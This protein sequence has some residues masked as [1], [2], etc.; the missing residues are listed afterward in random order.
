MTPLERC[1]YA[2]KGFFFWSDSVVRVIKKLNN[3]FA[4]CVD[5]EGKEC[6]AYGKGIGFPKT[7]YDITDSTVIDR[8]FY[9]VDQKYLALFNELPEKVLHFTVKLVDIARN[10][11]D[12][13]LNPNVVLTLAD[14]INFCIQRAKQHIYVQMPLIYEVEQQYPQE[15]RLGR[16]ALK[17]IERRFA[18]QLNQNEASGIALHF[19]NARYNA[20]TKCDVTMQW[21]QRYDDV[22]EDTVSIVEDEMGIVIN[23]CSF[24][25]ARYSSHLMYLLQRLGTG[26]LLDSN[27]SEMYRSLRAECPKIARCV[28]LIGEYFHNKWELTLSEEEKLYLL[29]HINRICTREGL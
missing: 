27:I 7:P 28:E 24:N 4:I 21:Q 9:D 22:L 15:G 29:L 23:R 5:S 26:N 2:L 6:I 1:N 12:Y 13:E 25:F 3:N 20:K 14:H 19:V 18:I 8:R 11:L 17:Q 10:E 16:Y